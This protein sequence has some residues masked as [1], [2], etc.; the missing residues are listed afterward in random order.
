MFVSMATQ[1]M[2]W[3]KIADQTFI[4]SPAQS[5]IDDYFDWARDCCVYNNVTNTVCQSG[6]KNQVIRILGMVIDTFFK[7]D[8][9]KK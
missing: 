3:S 5:W 2:Q 9:S 6:E 8:V 4:A 7:K 1:V